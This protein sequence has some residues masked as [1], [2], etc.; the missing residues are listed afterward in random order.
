MSYPYIIFTR[1]LCSLVCKWNYIKDDAGG[2]GWPRDLLELVGLED[3][4]DN[5]ASVIGKVDFPFYF[6][7]Y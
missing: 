1:S 4:L 3:L 5:D 2:Q 6:L 7:V